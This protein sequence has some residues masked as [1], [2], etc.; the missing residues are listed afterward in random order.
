ME[1]PNTLKQLDSHKII[2]LDLKLD[3]RE[4]E[5]TDPSISEAQMS[6]R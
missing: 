6:Y 3:K 4:K 1:Y 2:T 5:N